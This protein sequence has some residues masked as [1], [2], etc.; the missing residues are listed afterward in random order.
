MICKSAAAVAV[1]QVR[2]LIAKFGLIPTY[3]VRT[4][5]TS[6]PSCMHLWYAAYSYGMLH[7][8]MVCCMH[9]W[10]AQRIE[11][12]CLIVGVNVFFLIGVTL[13]QSHTGE[14]NKWFSL[15]SC[16]HLV[17]NAF[18]SKLQKLPFVICQFIAP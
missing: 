10:Y 16:V 12:Y 6:M 1:F 17:I 18:F 2:L 11:I 3:T 15:F 5:T 4:L 13:N 7:T 8:P 9:L 14:Q